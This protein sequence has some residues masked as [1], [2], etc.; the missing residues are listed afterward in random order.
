MNPVRIPTD[1]RYDN[2]ARKRLKRKKSIS[3]LTEIKKLDESTKHS[4]EF[5]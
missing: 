5:A 3:V 4:Q 1:Q 2:T